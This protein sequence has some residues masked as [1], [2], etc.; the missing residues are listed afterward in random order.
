MTKTLRENIYLDKNGLSKAGSVSLV[1]L[2]IY[3]LGPKYLT[4]IYNIFQD[5]IF[6]GTLRLEN[7][8]KL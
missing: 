2:E 8:S 5:Q 7:L 1:C 6:I 4:E 3:D